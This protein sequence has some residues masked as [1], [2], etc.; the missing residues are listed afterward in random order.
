MID[1]DLALRF[2]QISLARQHPD[3]TEVRPPTQNNTRTWKPAQPSVGLPKLRSVIPDRT[4]LSTNATTLGS[5]TDRDKMLTTIGHHDKAPSTHSTNPLRSP[6]NSPG[7]ISSGDKASWIPSTNPFR[8]L[9]NS[10]DM[11]PTSGD[12]VLDH[13]KRNTPESPIGPS[14]REQKLTGSIPV[15]SSRVVEKSEESESY[16][17]CGGVARDTASTKG[18]IE[19]T[20]VAKGKRPDRICTM[21]DAPPSPPI[22]MKDLFRSVSADASPPSPSTYHQSFSSQQHPSSLNRHL[23]EPNIRSAAAQPPPHYSLSNAPE[24]RYQQQQRLP[25]HRHSFQHSVT[26]VLP[27]PSSASVSADRRPS[28]AGS[29]AS[30]GWES[31]RAEP[32]QGITAATPTQGAHAASWGFSSILLNELPFFQICPQSRLGIKILPRLSDTHLGS[33]IRPVIITL[34][35]PGLD[36]LVSSAV[37][38]SF[39][40]RLCTLTYSHLP[41]PLFPFLVPWFPR[42]STTSYPLVRLYPKPTHL[43]LF[44]EMPSESVPADVTTRLSASITALGRAVQK[45]TV[46]LITST[47]ISSC[48]A[49][50]ANELRPVR[51]TALFMFELHFNCRHPGQNSR[52]SGN[53]GA[54]PRKTNQNA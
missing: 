26:P 17:G 43:S 22:A 41:R 24:T 16:D 19:P 34:R 4:S 40:L 20:E 2:L 10:P 27:S 50:G 3:T 5:G 29:A 37:I 38:L 11:T 8:S 28:T 9:P 31:I 52:S 23:S 48:S 33:P 21:L 15:D 51:S 7:M 14:P 12:N 44:P 1:T 47:P 18:R 54:R 13:R 30:S 42:K 36:H 25:Q 32:L 49:T 46:P 45:A 6:P 35:T 39:T 53:N